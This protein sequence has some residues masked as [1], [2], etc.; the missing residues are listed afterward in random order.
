MAGVQAGRDR[1]GDVATIFFAAREAAPGPSATSRLGAGGSAPWGKA[2][3]AKPP[4]A[5]YRPRFRQ[6][7]PTSAP[8][9]PHLVRTIPLADVPT[10]KRDDTTI[11]Q[12]DFRLKIPID[13]PERA[14]HE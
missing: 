5:C 7:G 14:S 2:D 1:R 8:T 13:S 10:P 3:S 6:F 12:S 9:M 11:S 4:S